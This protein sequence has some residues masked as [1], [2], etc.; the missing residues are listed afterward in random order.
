MKKGLNAPQS[1]GYIFPIAFSK[2]NILLFF[3]MGGGRGV[4][5]AL[6]FSPIS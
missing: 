6:M 5:V 1:W 4:I 3:V 2:S